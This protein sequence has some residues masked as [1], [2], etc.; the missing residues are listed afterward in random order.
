MS[1]NVVWPNGQ[2]DPG[3]GL[4]KSPSKPARMLTFTEERQAL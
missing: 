2:R 3:G 1:D 4:S